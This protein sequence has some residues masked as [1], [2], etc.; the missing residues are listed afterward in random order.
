MSVTF[1]FAAAMLSFSCAGHFL[2]CWTN[3]RLTFPVF[4]VVQAY[5]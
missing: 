3:D 5:V 1:V 4:L 2:E